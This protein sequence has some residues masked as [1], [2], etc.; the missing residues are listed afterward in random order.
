MKKEKRSEEIKKNFSGKGRGAYV[1]ES[2]LLN[3]FCAHTR[4]SLLFPCEVP[5]Q[6][7]TEN[8]RQ[9]P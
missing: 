1:R 6:T 3:T 2:I 8:S 7:L 4:N 9:N 5:P